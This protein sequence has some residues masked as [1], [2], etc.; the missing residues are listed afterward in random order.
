M[1]YLKLEIGNDPIDTR[2]I[3]EKRKM[4]SDREEYQ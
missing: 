4:E 3:A 1:K 2:K